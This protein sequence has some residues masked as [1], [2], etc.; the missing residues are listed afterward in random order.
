MT[1]ANHTIKRPFFFDDCRNQPVDL[2][3]ISWR[4]SRGVTEKGSLDKSPKLWLL[5]DQPMASAAG[6]DTVQHLWRNANWT[7]LELSCK[8]VLH[9]EK[10]SRCFRRPWLRSERAASRISHQNYRNHASRGLSS[11]KVDCQLIVL[12]LSILVPASYSLPH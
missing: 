5:H 10:Q 6:L 1:E 12:S 9:R 2:A 11:C 7:Y 4:K 3:D 8:D